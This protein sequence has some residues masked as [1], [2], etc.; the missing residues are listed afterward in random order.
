MIEFIRY[1]YIIIYFIKYITLNVTNLYSWSSQTRQT[2]AELRASPVPKPSESTAGIGTLNL[3]LWRFWESHGVSWSLMES[4]KVQ[5]P[6][7]LSLRKAYT[8]TLRQGARLLHA[9]AE[10]WATKLLEHPSRSRCDHT[11][12]LNVKIS[13]SWQGQ[14]ESTQEGLSGSRKSEATT[15]LDS[16]NEAQCCMSS[17]KLLNDWLQSSDIRHLT[18]SSISFRAFLLAHF[19]V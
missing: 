1:I 7:R 8:G 3:M 17:D 6:K 2:R 4:R 19:P 5:T 15:S 16:K 10:C 9:S 11:W 18:G 14:P 13:E 12:A